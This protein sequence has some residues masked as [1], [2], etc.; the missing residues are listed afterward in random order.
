MKPFAYPLIYLGLLTIIVFF[1]YVS[2]DI[3]PLNEGWEAAYSMYVYVFY[4]LLFVGLL[5]LLST[6]FSIFAQKR[7]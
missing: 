6:I 7:D 5:L 1:A 2:I 3:Y 4:L